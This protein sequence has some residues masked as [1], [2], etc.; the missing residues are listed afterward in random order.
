[1]HVNNYLQQYLL[2]CW[3]IP[4]VLY[5]KSLLDHEII[6]L[7]T[8]Y[9]TC[10]SSSV[11]SLSWRHRPQE[12][13]NNLHFIAEPGLHMKVTTIINAM[14]IRRSTK[15]PEKCQPVDCFGDN[16]TL[17]NKSDVTFSCCCIKFS[18]AVV[19]S[20]KVLTSTTLVISILSIIVVRSVFQAA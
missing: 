12:Q 9:Q 7:K 17:S 4:C 14:M 1:M 16:V 19:F 5:N 2:L 15:V 11:T 20:H 18:S 6:C 10:N 3:N 13:H 8:T